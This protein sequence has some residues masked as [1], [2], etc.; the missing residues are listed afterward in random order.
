MASMS[1]IITPNI[2]SQKLNTSW[3]EREGFNRTRAKLRCWSPWSTGRHRHKPAGWPKRPGC[4]TAGWTRPPSCQSRR[5]TSRCSSSA[6]S[7]FRLSWRRCTA[8]TCQSYSCRLRGE[9]CKKRV[10]SNADR[11]GATTCLRSSVVVTLNSEFKVWSSKWSY[12]IDRL[13]LLIALFNPIKV[14]FV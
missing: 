11:C 9:D 6:G 1:F 7:R 14:I 5:G 2:L 13:F 8:W 12:V 10:L 4:W 3:G